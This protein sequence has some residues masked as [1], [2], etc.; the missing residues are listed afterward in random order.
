MTFKS[1]LVKD[2]WKQIV[3]K[4]VRTMERRWTSL[5][6]VNWSL[7]R[8]PSKVEWQWLVRNG[9]PEWNLLAL[10]SFAE[11]DHGRF[12]LKKKK[13]TRVPFYD[14]DSEKWKQTVN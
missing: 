4:K 11:T 9:A 8:W 5:A 1:L 7:V 12:C 2:A 14:N 6:S 3:V 13:K 10:W